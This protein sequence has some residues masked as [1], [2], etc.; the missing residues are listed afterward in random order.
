MSKYV[1]LKAQAEK[2][3][4]QAELLLVKETKEAIVEI[5]RLM[6]LYNLTAEDIGLAAGRPPKAGSKR[7][8]KPGPRTAGKRSSSRAK[9]TGPTQSKD[10]RATVAPKYRDPATGA[11]WTG[12]GKKPKWLSAQLEAGQTIDQFKI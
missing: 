7:G 8:R 11:T 5:K 10:G 1:E 2:Y 6:K 12:R 4:K 9:K 3:L